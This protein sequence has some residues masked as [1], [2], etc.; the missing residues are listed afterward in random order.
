MSAGA[1]PSEGLTGARGDISKAVLHAAS[2][3]VLLGDCLQGHLDVLMAWGSA[4]PRVSN[5]GGQH[6]GCNSFM[7]QP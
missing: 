2:K 5:Q 3:V 4:S 1:A 7:M 6:E